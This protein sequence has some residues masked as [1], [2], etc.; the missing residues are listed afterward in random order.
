MTSRKRRLANLIQRAPWSI[1]AAQ[2]VW[3]RAVQPWVTAGTVGAVFD[4]AGRVLIVEHVFHPKFPWGLPGGWM[5]RGESPEQ[6]IARELLEET[7]L[8]VIV[9][10]PLL[11]SSTDYLPN[12]LDIA[13]LCRVLP[14]DVERIQLS[15]ELLDYRWIDP[16]DAPPLVT[17]HRQVIKAAI[18]DRAGQQL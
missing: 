15:G 11:I 10:K 18:A 5:N 17:F 3:R 8:H 12:H 14:D 7:A 9:E 2:I 6:T 16:N 4:E 1:R 13:F